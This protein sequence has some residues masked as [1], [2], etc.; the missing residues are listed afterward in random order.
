MS[1]T[2]QAD[3][4]IPGKWG[5][6]EARFYYD[7]E[8]EIV[9]LSLRSGEQLRGY[10]VGLDNYALVLERECDKRRILVHK[11]AIDTVAPG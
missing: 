8:G 2:T 9:T 4:K 11:H 1:K 5:T 6:S 10:V 7:T 3:E